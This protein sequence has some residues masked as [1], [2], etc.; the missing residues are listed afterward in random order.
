L[1]DQIN[2]AYRDIRIHNDLGDAAL[3]FKKRVE[4]RIAGD[5]PAGVGVEIMAGL[6]LLAF[7]VE[8][9]FNFLGDYL[10]AGWNERQR[11]E[12]KVKAVCNHLGVVPD[13]K[14][15]P[16]LSIEKLRRFRDTLAHGKPEYR[17]VVATAEEL[18]GRGTLQAEWEALI[19]DSKFFYEAYDDVVQIWKVLLANAELTDLDTS[20][21]GGRYPEGA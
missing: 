20:S 19:D 13:F 12:K 18:A 6:T 17:E 5:D 11:A 15:R 3:Y 16:Y 8:A 2:E 7:A 21:E 10:I 9:K 14:A 1:N 4:E